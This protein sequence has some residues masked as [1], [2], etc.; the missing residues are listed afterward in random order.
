M[1]DGWWMMDYHCVLTHEWRVEGEWG[2]GRRE[3]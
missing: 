2:Q 3:S 1:D